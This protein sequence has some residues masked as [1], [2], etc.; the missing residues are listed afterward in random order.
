MSLLNVKKQSLMNAVNKHAVFLLHH[1][2]L[3]EG[4]VYVMGINMIL[5]IVFLMFVDFNCA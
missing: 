2:E 3:T 1:A 5:H 4:A